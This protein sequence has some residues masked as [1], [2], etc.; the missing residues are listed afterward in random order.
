MDALADEPD[1]NP[2]AELRVVTSL[3]LT[4]AALPNFACVLY[5]LPD[6]VLSKLPQPPVCALPS[7]GKYDDNYIMI[8]LRII[9]NEM[10]KIIIQSIMVSYINKIIITIFKVSN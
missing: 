1:P 7:I 9:N 6:A 5:F 10:D 8:M 3:R 2:E 4:S